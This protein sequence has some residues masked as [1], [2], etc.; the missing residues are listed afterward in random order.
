MGAVEPCITVHEIGRYKV[1]WYPCSVPVAAFIHDMYTRAIITTE[2]ILFML[3]SICA[4]GRNDGT[5]GHDDGCFL[6]EYVL[7]VRKPVHKII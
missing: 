6:D 2:H 7:R 1:S 3:S 4:C 5:C